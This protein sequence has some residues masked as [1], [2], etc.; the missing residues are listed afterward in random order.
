MKN[1]KNELFK[2]QMTRKEFI[3]FAVMAILSVLGL[4]NF[5]SFLM[6]QTQS[7]SGTKISEKNSHG[8]GSSKFGA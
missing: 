1:T 3:Q 8:F 5:I 6:E 7:Q 2:Q 4:K